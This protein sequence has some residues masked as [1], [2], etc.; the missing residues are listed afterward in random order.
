MLNFNDASLLS[1]LRTQISNVNVRVM[2]TPLTD[3]TYP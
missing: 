3:I 1:V 2:E